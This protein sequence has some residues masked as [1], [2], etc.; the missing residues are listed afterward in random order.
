M[1]ATISKVFWLHSKK[2]YLLKKKNLFPLGANCFLLEKT[3]F[4]MG[5]NDTREKILS[6]LSH[7]QKGLAVQEGKLESQTLST[8]AEN[9]PNI[10]AAFKM[11]CKDYSTGTFI[12]VYNTYFPSKRITQTSDK[13]NLSSCWF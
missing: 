8:L 9:L 6:F 5:D 7:F 13:K 4:E 12:W 2:V 11:Y 3:P 10:S 1:Q